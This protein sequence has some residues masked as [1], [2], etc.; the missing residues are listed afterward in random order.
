M[1]SYSITAQ[2]SQDLGTVQD[3]ANLCQHKAVKVLWPRPG[4]HSK[5][6]NR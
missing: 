5:D 1:A 4:D 3:T 2:P 6:L